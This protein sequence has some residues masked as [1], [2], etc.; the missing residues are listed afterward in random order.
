MF[1]IFHKK[2]MFTKKDWIMFAAGAEAFHTISHAVL[3]LTNC[4]PIKF[5]FI[6]VGPTTNLVFIAV[7]AVITAL[8]LW[9]AS[10]L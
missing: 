4:M 7:N 6:T 2:P 10:K 9:W 5:F 3:P 1:N 8:L